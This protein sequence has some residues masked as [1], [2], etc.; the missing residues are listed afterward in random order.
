MG[1]PGLTKEFRARPIPGSQG[2]YGLISSFDTSSFEY[3]I[4]NL[5]SVFVSS[6]ASINGPGWSPPS[7]RKFKLN[8]DAAVDMVGGSVGI[9]ILV[10]DSEGQVL[11]S[12]A[13]K[14]VDGY[15]P[16]IAE[17]MASLCGLQFDC[18]VGLWPCEVDSDAQV[19]VKL[20]NGS[21]IPSPVLRL[22]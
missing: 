19:V 5:M 9:R 6:K 1:R 16:Q 7:V 17:A 21:D 15:P 12:S 8:T 3:G 20:V 2:R 18:D 14:I 11:A 22:V 13:Q 4:G 10:R